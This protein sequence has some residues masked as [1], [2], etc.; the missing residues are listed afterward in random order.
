MGFVRIL[1]EIDAFV[2]NLKDDSKLKRSIHE[3]EIKKKIDGFKKDLTET[4]EQFKVCTL[5]SLHG[6]AF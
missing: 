3:G 6:I 2:K 1:E 5:R 4:V